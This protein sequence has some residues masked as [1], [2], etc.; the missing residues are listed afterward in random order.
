MIKGITVVK[1]EE[2]NKQAPAQEKA[3]GAATGGAELP[4][5]AAED[6][7]AELE[8]LQQQLAECQDRMLRMAADFDNTKKR[9]ERE[10]QITIKFAEENILREL[11]PSIDNLERAMEQGKETNKV[12]GLLEGL[13][14]TMNGLLGTLEKFGVKQVNSIGE[15]FDPNLHEAMA[16]ETSTEVPQN[17]VLREFQ[18]GYSYKDRLLRAAK[19][20]VSSGGPT[21]QQGERSQQA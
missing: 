18:K 20:I 7:T 13:A 10:C 16:T 9:L 4:E 1:K 17:N 19:V 5:K 3:G 12:D 21:P 11:L 14:L 2:K 15:P 6:L 8:A